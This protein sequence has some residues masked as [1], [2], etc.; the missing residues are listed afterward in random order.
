M[1]RS[2]RK[3]LEIRE[4]EDRIV[5]VAREILLREGFPAL[6]MDRIAREIGWSRGTIYQHYA[7][8]EDV[9][10]AMMV[11][12]HARRVELFD[13]AAKRP[14]SPRQ[15]IAAIGVAI[16]VFMELHPGYFKAE[17]IVALTADQSKVRWERVDHCYAQDNRCFDVACGIVREAIERGDL[18]LPEDVA[19]ETVVFGLWSINFGAHF[20]GSAMS[21]WPELGIQGTIYDGLSFNILAMLD[22]LGWRPLSTEFDYRAFAKEERERILADRLAEHEA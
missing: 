7:S 13:S 15:R 10:A 16:D 9:L 17:Q 1:V 11:Q 6:N 3:Q 18:V 14:G 20:I 22:G 5:E 2:A 21:K 4:R 8:K 12:T 19:L